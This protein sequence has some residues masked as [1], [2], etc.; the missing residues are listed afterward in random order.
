MIVLS[1]QEIVASNFP[2]WSCSPFNAA[3]Y[4]LVV[5]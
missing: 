2:E 1:S 3:L 4:N 5:F